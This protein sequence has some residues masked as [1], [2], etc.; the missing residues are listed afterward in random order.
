MT[1]PDA[2][3]A[4]RPVIGHFERLNVPYYVGGSLASSAYGKPRTS[5]DAD[6]VA[7]L[8]LE[9][10]NPLVEGLQEDYYVSVTAVRDAVARRAC[11]NVVH[12][13]TA[14]KVDV[15]AMRARPY[16]REA[17][18]RARPEAIDEDAPGSQF[19][20]AAPED[21]VLSKLEWFRLGNEVSERQWLDVLGV[22]AVQGDRLDRAYLDRWAARLGVADLLAR[23]RCEA[24]A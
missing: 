23:A 2:I 22:L 9:H 10:V 11:F 17:L 14:F 20:L 21:V 15:F 24:H 4:V 8:A 16:D 19:M 3:T 1:H 6:L 5:I 18:G 13:A 7:D 12:Y